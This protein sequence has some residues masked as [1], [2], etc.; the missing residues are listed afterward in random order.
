M[1]KTIESSAQKSSL[2]GDC[3]H[4][5]QDFNLLRYFFSKREGASRDSAPCSSPAPTLGPGRVSGAQG[6]L[7]VN[8]EPSHSVSLDEQ[9]VF[10]HVTVQPVIVVTVI[11]SLRLSA[12]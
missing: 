3:Y 7:A 4:L 10:C 8:L 2:K 9:H 12:K 5:H 6:G 1:Q 11:T